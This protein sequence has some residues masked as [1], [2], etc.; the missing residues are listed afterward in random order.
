MNNDFQWT[1]GMWNVMGEQNE[2][3]HIKTLFLF[4]Y[5]AMKLLW[6]CNAGKNKRNQANN[7]E[8]KCRQL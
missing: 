1:G 3:M 8:L 5:V 7:V 4:V 6:K 2:K